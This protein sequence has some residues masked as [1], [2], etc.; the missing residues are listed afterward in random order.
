MGCAAVTNSQF[1]NWREAEAIAHDAERRAV[2]QALAFLEGGGPA[3]SQEQWD[4]CKKLRAAA[5]A[6]FELVVAEWNAPHV[7]EF[8]ARGP[9]ARG[10]RAQA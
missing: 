1:S 3:P 2:A 9:H 10:A 5:N 8:R 6:M 7:P 4:E